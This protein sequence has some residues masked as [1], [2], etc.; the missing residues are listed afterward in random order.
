MGTKSA[1]DIDLA[2]ERITLRAAATPPP[3]PPSRKPAEPFTNPGAS[4][5]APRWFLSAGA[6]I[7]PVDVEG[8][9]ARWNRGELT[10]DSLVWRPGLSSWA[11]L[12]TV[13]ELRNAISPL[14]NALSEAALNQMLR[15]PLP[16]ET[17]AEE[18]WRPNAG[19]QMDRL[20]RGDSEA[21]EG[22]MAQRLR[23][24]LARPGDRSAVIAAGRRVRN[25]VFR[26]PG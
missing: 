24:R 20:L 13:A 19:Q 23:L 15:T 2:F 1:D 9:R 7:A 22:R 25:I 16:V 21:A 8:L 26:R 10:P 5:L 3:L 6:G 17:K 14:P 11:R 18:T 4:A 12:G